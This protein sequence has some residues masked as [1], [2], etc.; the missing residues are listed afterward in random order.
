MSMP[1]NR[2]FQGTRTVTQVN[3]A[4]VPTITTVT[5]SADA[6]ISSSSAKQKTPLP[7]RIKTWTY[8]GRTYSRQAGWIYPPKK[9]KVSP[10]AWR[11]PTP[12]SCSLEEGDLTLFN[13]CYQYHDPNSPASYTE[14]GM[15]R[16]DSFDVKCPALG[17]F[18][19]GLSTR[20]EI[21]ALN[22]L[23]DQSVNL[24][25]AFAERS[26]TAALLVGTLSGLAK[27][28]RSLS[29]GDMRG[30]AR[31]LGLK[32]SPKVPRGQT[33]P[34]KWLELQYGWQPLYNDVFGAVAA[35]HS[36]DQS[37]P[38]RYAQTVKGKVSTTANNYSSAYHNY[39][40]R[41]YKQERFSEGAFVRLDYFLRN[42][43]LASLAS[44]G[45]TNPAEV[46]WE[47]VPFSFVVDWFIPIGSYLSS[48]DSALGWDFRG[49]SLTKVKRRFWTA[50]IT[51][52][53]NPAGPNG[54]QAGTIYG[55]ARVRQLMLS[56]TVYSK[57]PVPRVPPFKN[58]FPQNGK[59]IANALALFASSLR[60]K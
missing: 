11:N 37:E 47:R 60:S 15:L 57:S 3:N 50:G 51:A 42:P 38:K 52:A 48:M 46:V 4:G 21:A 26:E 7:V 32:G 23:K 20:A 5:N 12:Y 10:T 36:A 29:H 44:L 59:H 58:P 13:G 1:G 25:V 56:R 14:V 9:R 55:E 31:G 39:C 54:F 19:P 34:Q 30:V 6:V 40:Y 17:S 33:F 49:G 45:I 2:T 24:A 43:F 35:L 27:A 18:D 22:K 8:A 53:P 16:C 28:A 41:T